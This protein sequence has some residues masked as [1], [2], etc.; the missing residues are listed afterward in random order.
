MYGR[1]FYD[2]PVYRLRAEQYSQ[3]R[4]D[5]IEEVLFPPDDPDREFLI[6]REKKDPGAHAY[7]RDH[8]ERSYGGCWRFNEIIGYI[9]LHFLGS[10]VRGEYFGVRRKRLVRTRTKVLEW[11]T[12]KL[13][14][15]VDIEPPFTSVE[16]LKAIHQYI[17]RC[18]KKL[19]G[20]HI[21]TDVF[22]AIAEFVDWEAVYRAR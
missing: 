11:Q 9:R 15:E 18:K 5:H 17:D 8:L 3:Q 1:H 7:I 19:K 6:Q 20:K 21:D 13:A 14:P 12:H 22:N 2:L 10:Q 16:I 4:R